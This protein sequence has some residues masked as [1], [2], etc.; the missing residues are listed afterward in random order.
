MT[1]IGV[2]GGIGSGKST[3][4]RILCDLGAKIVD[5]DRIAREVVRKGENALLEIVDYFGAGI[6]N[7]DSDLD[8]KRLAAE[9][10]DNPEKLKVLNDI[11]HK[12]VAERIIELVELLKNKYG[13]ELIVVD[14]PIPVEHGFV[15]VVDAI[16]VVTADMELRASRVM[17]RSGLSYEDVVKRMRMQMSDDEYARIADEL[18]IN[19]STFEELEEEVARLYIKLQNNKS[20]VERT[21][22]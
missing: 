7:A 5:A 12:Y 8:R 4:S 21:A 3:V 6:L 13:A 15:D 9:V 10:F 18:I 2:T 16:W 17:E 11:T 1:V 19:N 20:K 14:V 22:Q